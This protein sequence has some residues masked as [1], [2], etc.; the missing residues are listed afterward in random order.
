MSYSSTAHVIYGIV[1]PAI[2]FEKTKLNP[3]WGKY[4]FDPDTGNQ[5]TEF[6]TE[7][8]QPYQFGDEHQLECFSYWGE[9]GSSEYRTSIA[10]GISLLDD[11]AYGADNEIHMDKLVNADETATRIINALKSIDIEVTRDKIKLYCINYLS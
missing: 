1:L 4:R 5:V 9:Y 7:C 11:R 8:I 6:I 2:K 10:L 3:L